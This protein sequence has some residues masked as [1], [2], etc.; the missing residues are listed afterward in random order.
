MT[1]PCTVVKPPYW[2]PFGDGS[3]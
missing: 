1:D 2:R 3:E